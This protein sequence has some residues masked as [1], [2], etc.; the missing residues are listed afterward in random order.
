MIMS[1]N[2]LLEFFDKLFS[3][4]VAPPGPGWTVLEDN[5]ELL[6]GWTDIIDVRRR[7]ANIA[8]VAQR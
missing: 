8:G 5:L 7:L 1:C 4:Y 3:W 6:D 2:E